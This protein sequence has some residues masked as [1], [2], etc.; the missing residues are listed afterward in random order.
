MRQDI[1]WMCAVA[2][3]AL[4]GLATAATVGTDKAPIDEVTVYNDRAQVE[5]KTRLAI[6]AGRSE[7][8]FEGLPSP[9]LEGSIRSTIDNARIEVIGLTQREEVHV[10]ERREEVREL[11]KQVR[12]LQKEIRGLQIQD[13]Q[14]QTKLQQIHQFRSYTRSAASLQLTETDVDVN[15]LTKT[16]DLFQRE[17]EQ[18][19][20][21]RGKI[22]KD[23]SKL[24]IDLDA[25]QD[26]MEDLRYGSERSSTTVTVTVQSKLPATANVSVSYGVGGVSWAPRYDLRYDKEKLHLAYLAQ[27]YQSSGEDWNDVNL[28]FTTARPDDMAP[29]PENEALYVSGYTEKLATVQLGSTREEKKDEMDQPVDAVPAPGAAVAVVQRSL[30]VDLRV[31]H[32]STVP[33]D[34]RPYRIAVLETPLKAEVDRYAAPALSPQLFMRAQTHNETGMILLPGPADIYRSSGYVGTVWL[35]ELAS[36]E[37]FDLSLG[38]AGPLTVTRELDAHR[39][40]TVEASATRKKV[41][42]VYK[43]EVHNFGDDATEVTLSDSVPVSRVDQVKITLGDDTT[44]GFTK[45]QDESIYSWNLKI[46]PGEKKVV[47][48]S[49]IV[50]LPTDY[51]WEGF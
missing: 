28:V 13:S 23:R 47:A 51:A 22:E 33:A 37:K 21:E 49:Y 27:V 46:K 5:R 1:K 16:L 3:L 8:T 43:M 44:P 26:R 15:T 14:L 30:A 50:D 10:T 12:D 40:R 34:G 7:I 32:P 48:L 11:E 35:E 17:S 39:N 20:K 42:F 25:L 2:V 45:G 18:I 38:P 9:L 4:P 19:I 41:H 31:T 29:P 36:G 24:D 6:P